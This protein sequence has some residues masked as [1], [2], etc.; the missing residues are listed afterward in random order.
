MA[1]NRRELLIGLSTLGSYPFLGTRAAASTSA[2][3]IADSFT[4]SLP[5]TAT[6][7]LGKKVIVVGAGIGGLVSAYELQ[8]AGFDVTVFEARDRVGGRNWTLRRG[9]KVEYTD[10]TTQTVQFD[11]G[12]YFNAGPARIPSH[13]QIMLG[14]CQELGVALEV[15]VNTSRNALVRPDLAEPPFQLRQAVNDA[16]GYIAELLT[17]SVKNDSA[18]QTLSKADRKGLQDFLKIW[19][20][21]SDK[22]TYEGSARSG[23]KVLPGSGDQLP[24]KRAPL[25]LKSLLNPALWT[26][27]VIDEYPEFSPT[28]FQ[29]VGGMD[30]IP[31]AFH[32]RLGQRVRF[33]SEVQIIE[34]QEASA[35]VVV[36]DRLT[37]QTSTLTADYVVVTLPLPLLTK[38]Q[39]NFSQPVKDAIAAT[40]FGFANKVAWQSPRFWET[41]LQ[42]YGGLSFLNHDAYSFWYPSGGFQ[43][44]EGVLIGAYNNGEVARRFG[45]KSH[46]EQIALSKQAVELLHPNRSQL[47]KNPVAISWSRIPYSL[48]PWSSHEVKQ[49]AYDLLNQPQGRVHLSSDSLAH[50]GIGI[51]QESAA[52]S[53]RRV[54]HVILQQAT[55]TGS[56]TQGT[57]A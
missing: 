55:Q 32:K 53:A 35:S 26:A 29:P 14:Y 51:W 18:P 6:P 40:E 23:Y 37:G 11:S 42:I 22:Q 3:A 38:L 36:K 12:F 39:T 34:S 25:P 30:Q 49:P 46:L 5:Q 2:G 41:D 50:S 27:L 7:A 16:R 33:N 47:L 13:H 43:Q 54:A 52:A 15:V 31:K 9:D 57:A 21:L 19:G 48:G 45:E 1:L 17:Q 4:P 24:V 28:M 20:D 44:P 10:G 8:R 56:V